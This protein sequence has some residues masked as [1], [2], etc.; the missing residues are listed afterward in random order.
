[1]LSLIAPNFGKTG[2][3]DLIFFSVK[4]QN[5]GLL[6]MYF[7]KIF[8]KGY[9]LAV[10]TLAATYVIWISPMPYFVVPVQPS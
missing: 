4:A 6:N 1:M 7:K 5:L 3:I 8:L 2:W 9:Y 10:K